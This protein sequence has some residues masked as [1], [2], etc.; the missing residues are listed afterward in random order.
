MLWLTRRALVIVNPKAGTKKSK[1]DLFE[2]IDRL[3]KKGYSVSA[4]TTTRQGDGTRF[5]CQYGEGQDLIICCGGDGTLN[6]VLNGILEMGISA[7]LGYVPAGTTN[8]FARTFMLPK[9]VEKSM[10]LI[11]GGWPR[12]CDIGSFNG[13]NFT[14]I[15]SLGAFTNVSYSTPQKLKNVFG[16]SAYLW[17]GIKEVRN[18]SPFEAEFKAN[19]ET[20]AG[21]FVFG[22][23][24]NSTS[25]GGL[26]KLN[27]LDV[28]MDDGEFELMLIRNPKNLNDLGGIIDGL[29]R[30]KYDPRYVVFTH[31]GAVDI[32]TAKP[33]TWTLDGESGGAQQEV[34]ID[35]HQNAF[36]L[37]V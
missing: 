23:I 34:H 29:V 27:N 35:V 26:F 1:K 15:A 10:D 5:V 30:G 24:S 25:I 3:S 36:R 14:Y 31:A 20:F 11:L 21:E 8:D 32:K 33:Q 28:R 17:E 7:P 6:E 9:K 37:I 18:I 4:Q 16:H 19:G 13:R 2:I 22:S 12:Y